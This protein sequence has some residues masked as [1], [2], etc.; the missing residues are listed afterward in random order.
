MTA[1]P[2]MCRR[3]HTHDGVEQRPVGLA[4]ADVGQCDPGCVGLGQMFGHRRA[5]RHL[6]RS[7]GPAPRSAGIRE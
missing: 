4:A 1:P 3:A 5:T 6:S 2:R 7:Q